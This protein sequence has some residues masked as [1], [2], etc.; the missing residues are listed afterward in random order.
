MSYFEKFSEDHMLY[1]VRSWCMFRD[2][3][4]S[5]FAFFVLR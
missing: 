2:L 1:P 4:W 3:T 5:S